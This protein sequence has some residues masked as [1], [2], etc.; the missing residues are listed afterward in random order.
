MLNYGPTT[1]ELMA[2]GRLRGFK[3]LETEFAGTWTHGIQQRAIVRDEQ[4]GQHY[5]VSYRQWDLGPKT[6]E[7]DSFEQPVRVRSELRSVRVWLTDD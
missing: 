4:S 3:L 2:L 7:C 5:A 1:L 6:G